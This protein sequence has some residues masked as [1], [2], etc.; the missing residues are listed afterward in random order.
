MATVLTAIV[1]IFL[2]YFFIRGFKNGFFKIILTTMSLIVTIVLAAAL[3]TP[4]SKYLQ[5][6]T[7]LGQ[8]FENKVEAYL[9]EKTSE[10]EGNTDK[11]AVGEN[12]GGSQENATDKSSSTGETETAKEN[13]SGGT[14]KT[15][16]EIINETKLPKILKNALIKSNNAAEY[17]KLGVSD[18]K[19]YAVKSISNILLKILVYVALVIAIFIVIRILLAVSKVLT[20]IPVIRG[21]NRFFGA[22][23]GLLQGLLILWLIGFVISLISNTGFGASVVDVLHKNVFLT[24]LYDNNCLLKIVKTIITFF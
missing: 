14:D 12:A 22:L 16:E 9:F 7:G 6:N 17:V 13:I 1:I 4:V 3:V 5:E 23:L 2:L 21:I 18:F 19:E 15:E 8:K 24:F 10:G 11:K 20:K